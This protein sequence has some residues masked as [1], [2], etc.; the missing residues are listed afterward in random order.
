MRGDYSHLHAEITPEACGK[1]RTRASGNDESRIT[2][3]VPALNRHQLQRID[4]RGMSDFDDRE[5]RIL[6][7][8]PH[9]PGN[10]G[11]GGSGPGF[12]EPHLAA[13]KACRIENAECQQ[14]VGKGGL[15]PAAAVAGRPRCRAGTFRSDAKCAALVDAG[16]RAAAG[17]DFDDIDHRHLH[18]IAGRD[19][20]MLELVF[21]IERRTVVMDQRAFRRRAADIERQHLGFT[22]H[23]TDARSTRHTA[24]WSGLHK[25][26][27]T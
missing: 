18:R 11:D 24:A 17:A 22:K 13:G 9:R 12:V 19:A 26:Q 10:R 20:G 15:G 16:N 3:I 25:R 1:R 6:D 21:A 2:R 27:R 8:Q 5:S 14:R 23:G 7:R 4:H